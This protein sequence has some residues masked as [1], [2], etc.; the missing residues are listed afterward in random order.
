M[1]DIGE[2]NIVAEFDKNSGEKLRVSLGSYRGHDLVNLRVWFRGEDDQWHP[3][4]KGVAISTELLPD[5]IDALEKAR[6]S[7]PEAVGG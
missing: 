7:L 2:E 6:A 4:R 3:T 5:L 1:S